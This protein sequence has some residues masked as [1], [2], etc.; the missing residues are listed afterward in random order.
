MQRVIVE[1]VVYIYEYVY[2]HLSL[3][4]IPKFIIHKFKF[5]VKTVGNT[6]THLLLIKIGKKIMRSEA[7]N[8]ISRMV[9]FETVINCH[10]D[11][12]DI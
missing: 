7:S 3:F 9:L 8:H 10:Y 1:V 6:D 11:D 2:Y 12:K 5:I 4:I